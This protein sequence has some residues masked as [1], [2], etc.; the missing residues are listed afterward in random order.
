LINREKEKGTKR[1]EWLQNAG[2]MGSMME[3]GGDE[4]RSENEGLAPGQ[5]MT[6]EMILEKRRLDN[7][8]KD[9]FSQLQSRPKIE[10]RFTRLT[11]PQM[12]MGDG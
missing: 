3:G 12:D 6:R 4:S 9:A 11:P 1:E 8:N 2:A 7:V 5:R 10:L